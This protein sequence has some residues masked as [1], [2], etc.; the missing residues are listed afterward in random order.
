[1]Q[2]GTSNLAWYPLSL[3]EAVTSLDTDVDNGLTRSEVLDRQTRFGPNVLTKTAGKSPLSLFLQ[4]FKNPMI[5]ILLAAT[6]VT[7]ILQEYVEA[8]V[9]LVIVLTNAVIGFFQEARALQAMEA[10]SQAMEAEATVMREGNQSRIPASQLVPGDLVILQ[11]GDKVPADLRLV[12]V[13]EL[14]VDESALTGESVPVRKQT[15]SLAENTPL[16]DRTNMAYSSALVTYGTGA[17][18]VIAIGDSTEIGHINQMIASADVLETPLTRKIHHFSQI[19]LFAI[20]GLS[21]AVLAFALLR[22]HPVQDVFLEVVA[23]A[24]AAIPESLP[25]V[26]TIT[27]ALGV[28]RMAERQAIIRKL[29]AVETLGSTTVICS[30][31]TGTLTQNEMT[32]QAVLAGGELYDVSGV[33]YAPKGAFSRDGIGVDPLAIPALAEIL[34]GGLLCND[35]R[36][37]PTAEGLRVEG[38]PTEGALVTS[39]NKAGLGTEM[40]AELPRMDA[41]PFE[42]EYMYMATL[43]N[44]GPGKPRIVYA[45]GSVE[46]IVSRCD[47]AYNSLMQRDGLKQ[48]AILAQVRKMA[49]AGLRVLAFARGELPAETTSIDHEHIAGG[50]IFLGLQAMI[51]PP[52]PET[53]LAVHDCYRAGVRVKMITGDHVVTATAIANQIVEDWAHD[54]ALLRGYDFEIKAI[55][56]QG[57]ESLAEEE[58]VKTANQTHVF[59]RVAPEQKLRLVKALQAAGNVV[60]MTGDGV[61]DAPALRQADIGIAMGITGTAAAKEAADMVLADDNFATIKDAIQ[62]GRAVYDNIIKFITWTLPTNIAEGGVI[63]LAWIFG[64]NLPITPLQILWINTVTAGLL[65]LML[66]FEPEEPGSMARPPRD[67]T[68]SILSPGLI[69]RVILIGTLLIIAV[70]L[71]YERAL[72]QHASIEAARTAAVNA[73]VF[74]E[75]L[76]LLNCRSLRYSL[77]KIGFLSNRPLIGGVVVMI[78]LQLVFTYA[79]F[80][81]AIF[82]TAPIGVEQWVLILAMSF[83]IFITVEME[84]WLGQ[85]QNKLPV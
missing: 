72:I 75:I 5:Y 31:K 51:D 49:E 74:G 35:S 17:G 78:I 43:H 24:I 16:A 38:D 80:M 22:G 63:L 4:Q 21:A 70:F 67:V 28:T 29:P 44:P 36:L 83:V 79:G 34:K 45:K 23:L 2:N 85:R 68:D 53:A 6:I 11:S 46:A 65:G 56:G 8:I 77:N 73:I 52:R 60:A 58:L 57:L 82:H 59:A 40:A 39:A 54:E 64:W 76:Y 19:L 66:A 20:L 13:R 81:N 32:V 12:R 9:I 30:D 18:L 47:S 14:Q 26:V 62:E 37:A 1:M 25:A 3:A 50:L 71:V 61:N 42:S 10:L 15:G 55:D 48:D 84:K 33:G 69:G 7:V 41:I 27:L